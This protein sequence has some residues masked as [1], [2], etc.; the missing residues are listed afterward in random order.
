[1]QAAAAHLADHAERGLIRMAELANEPLPS[2][3]AV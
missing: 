1:V 2:I 3:D